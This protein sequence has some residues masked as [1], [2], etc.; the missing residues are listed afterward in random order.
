MPKKDILPELNH[1]TKRV[2]WK[3]EDGEMD[4]KMPVLPTLEYL[5]TVITAMKETLE[6]QMEMDRLLAKITRSKFKA[7]TD[8][9]FT[10]AQALELCKIK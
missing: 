6:A 4:K 2:N 7:L 10:E 9:G 5:R 3:S 8:E 1:L